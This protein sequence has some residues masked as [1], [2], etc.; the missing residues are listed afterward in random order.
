M[1][2]TI[3]ALATGTLPCAIAIIRV[4]GPNA[5][6]SFS[7]LGVTQPVARHATRATLRD[8]VGTIDE[9]LVL[10]FPGPASATGENVAEFHVHGS[11]AVVRGVFEVLA[12][13]PGLRPAAPGEFTR[14]AFENGRIDLS[15]AEA[16][17]AL[18]A[19]ETALQRR[20]AIAGLVGGLRD[21]VTR[22][23]GALNR[24][25]A[26]VEAQL[27]FSDEG[28]IGDDDD[29]LRDAMVLADE[30]R[31]LVAAPPAERLIDGVRV[32]LSGAPNAGKSS[33]LN[34]LVGRVAA[35]VTPIAGTTR[36]VIEVPV[37]IDGVPIM[38]VDTAG[39]CETSDFVEAIG[40]ERAIDAVATA[41]IILALDDS[42]RDDPRTIAIAAK[43]DIASGIGHRCSVIDRRGI[44]ALLAMVMA[45]ARAML[46]SEATVALNARQRS[47]LMRAAAALDD[48]AHHHDLILAAEEL[49]IARSAL[50]AITGNGDVEA[51]L[52]TVFSTF[53]VGK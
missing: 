25:A 30:M 47:A 23:E 36:D 12:T 41:D 8:D 51:L 6:D 22:W 16:L 9:A 11:R 38:F 29:V 48:A 43:A 46:P 10:W 7:A 40:V 20:A 44:D 21:A 4:S 35:I 50:G 17:G 28:D 3:F 32:V 2:D 49:R 37:V 14:R 53:C 52:D 39:M 45:K 31:S 18:L 42:Y 26:R 15:Q 5:G 24:L 19:A 34:A 33:L 27:D 1:N 13:L